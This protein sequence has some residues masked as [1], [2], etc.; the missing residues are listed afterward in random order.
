MDNKKSVIGAE[1]EFKV[2]Y[3]NGSLIRFEDLISR[4]D[5]PIIK[6]SEKGFWWDGGYLYEDTNN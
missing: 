3:P 4:I 1:N 2:N 6:Q 5:K